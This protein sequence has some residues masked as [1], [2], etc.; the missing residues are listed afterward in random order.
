MTM[1]I[2]RWQSWTAGLAL[3]LLC[4]ARVATAELVPITDE[5]DSDL[6]VFPR[7]GAVIQG[8]PAL[9]KMEA[10]DALVVWLAGNQFFAM[11]DVVH[12]FQKKHPDLDVG[13]VTLP[14]ILL[15]QAIQAGG[16]TYKG[17]SFKRLPEVY[18]SVST[19]HLKQTGRIKSYASYAHNRLELMVASGNPKSIADLRDLAR[20]D[21]QVALPN[22]LTEGIMQVYAKPIL[23]RLGLW[24]SLSPGE[25]CLDCD[26]VAHVHFTRVHHREIPERIRA[27]TADAGLVWRTEGLAARADGGVDAVVLPEDQSAVRDVTY[28]AGVLEASG[29]HVAADAFLAFLVSTEGQ[30]VYESFGFV[31]ATPEERRVNSLAAD[32]GSPGTASPAQRPS[33]S[34]AMNPPDESTIPEG[35][36][37]EAVRMGLLIV[38][39]P[40]KYA[41]AF[42]G[43]N[44]NC[45]SCHLDRGR[46]AFAAPWVG[47]WGMFPEYRS[48]SGSV[49]LLEDRINDCFRRSLNGKPLPLDGPEMRGVMAY[50]R[51]LSSG[52]PVGTEVKGRGFS[53]LSPPATPDPEHGRVQFE[54]RCSSCHGSDGQGKST[55]EGTYLYPPLWGS[56]S[57]NI[58]A[59]MARVDTAAA[60]IKANMPLG[61]GGTLGDQ[62]A[63]DIASYFT[64][65]PRPDFP[66]KGKDWPKGGKP[67]DAR[68]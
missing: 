51:W 30:A 55:A 45:T 25:D 36:F 68:Y 66:D 4:L 39:D 2:G 54:Q 42:A 13:V 21:V 9:Q 8:V 27:G 59:G 20:S 65:Q 44:L 7:G 60:F 18:G 56:A 52:V 64:Q 22:A 10:G 47:L 35:P 61:Q 12:A 17:H 49:I 38:T 1:R 26:P 3:G 41:P 23:K 37:G 57:F 28:V 34:V 19:A 53:R 43:S 50:M 6:R 48:R 15:L 67:R 58:G 31:P 29:Q 62:D 46:T 11:E 40:R 33:A 5:R 63:Y 24:A 14:P 16:L 32:S